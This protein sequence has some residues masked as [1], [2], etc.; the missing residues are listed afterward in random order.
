MKPAIRLFFR[1]LRILLGPIMLLK[2][3][4][5]R[6]AALQRA[7][8]RQAE[9]DRQC[10]ELALYQ[11]RTCPFCI[12]VRQEMHRL[13][14]PIVRLDAQHDS[15]NRTALLK[16]SGAAKVPCLKITSASGSV[17]WL[18]DSGTIIDYLRGRFAA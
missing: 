16:G 11:F 15:L 4:L 1:T 13:S 5:S 10:Q 9:V 7:T 17:Q 14:L 2:E 8:A 3:R 18:T 12:K 6:P